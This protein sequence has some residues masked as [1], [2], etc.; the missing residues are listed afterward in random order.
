MFKKLAQKLITERQKRSNAAIDPISSDFDVRK[1]IFLNKM[2]HDALKMYE[3][4]TDISNFSKLVLSD[5]ENT[6][7]NRLMDALFREGVIDPFEDKKLEELSD[8]SKFLRDLGL[9]D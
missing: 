8:N 2:T 5:P 7:H 6:S 4:Q 1:K 3:R 9:L